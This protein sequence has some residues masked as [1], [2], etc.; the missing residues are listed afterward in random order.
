MNDNA[1][2]A[3]STAP[4]GRIRLV[5]GGPVLVDGPIDIEHD[6]EVIHCDRFRVALCACGRSKIKPFCDTSHRRPR[7]R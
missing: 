5:R 6:G 4:S 3:G 2:R 7:R 1:R